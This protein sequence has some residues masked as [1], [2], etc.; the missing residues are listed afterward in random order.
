MFG[1]ARFGVKYMFTARPQG[2]SSALQ[3]Y[4]RQ[5]YPAL[6][7]GLTTNY[8]IHAKIFLCPLLIGQRATA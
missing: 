1:Y 7:T 2:T 6:K 4:D 5:G 3:G 8:T